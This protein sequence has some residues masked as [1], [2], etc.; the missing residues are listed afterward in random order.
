[1]FFVF[2]KDKI[3]TYLVALISVCCMLIYV[4]V[5]NTT[6]DLV[7]TSSNAISNSNN[8]P[9]YNV[10]T[11]EKKVSLT[12]DCAWSADDMPSILET[13]EKNNIKATFFLVGSWIDKYPD[14]VNQMAEKG[15]DVANHS[16]TH[17]HV[18]NIGYEKN[19][20]EI[21]NCADK[22]EILT[23][24]RSTL[25]RGPYGEYNDTVLKAANEQNHTTIQ[26]NIDSLD[27]KGLTGEQMIERIS[28]KLENG[29]IILLHN[30]TKNTA[31]SLQSIIDYIK[32][33]GYEM[34]KVSELIYS[35]NYYI[36]SQ[37]T[38]IKN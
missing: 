16:D 21:A 8:L 17:C 30:G 3:V 23:K 36:N 29:S 10:K 38:Q 13:L 34:V 27:W 11:D 9:I 20:K 4:V 2:N 35:D 33:Q 7:Q 25:Y 12:F 15:H 31:S 37:G 32:S 14:T 22:I 28:Q 1:M 6:E 5:P 24:T 18:A 19:V 26:W